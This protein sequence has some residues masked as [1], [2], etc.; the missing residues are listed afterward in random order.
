MR[1]IY[2]YQINKS[3]VGKI[4]TLCG[5]V[6][7]IRDCGKLLFIDF[8]DHTG[9]IQICFECFDKNIHINE[10]KKLK[11]ESCVQI[12]GIVKI[13]KIKSLSKEPQEVE[14][15]ATNL[16]IINIS[17]P[18]PIDFNYKNSE[19]KYLK[20]RYLYIRRSKLFKI[21][22]LRSKITNYIRKVMEKR[23]FIDI[24]T[25]ILSHSTT[26]GA[27]DY[28]VHSRIH[29][30]MFYS[31]P[32]SPQ[33]FKQILMISGIDKYYQIAKC[34]RD[35]D[36]RSDRQPEFTQVDCEIS[37]DNGEK[38]RDL[39]EIL[40]KKLWIKFFNFELNN[41]PIITYNDSIIRF[42]SD[43]PDLRNSLELIN[44]TNLFKINERNKIALSK[45]K[46]LAIILPLKVKLNFDKLKKY[47]NYLKYYIKKDVFLAYVEDI[48][49]YEFS[50][51]EEIICNDSNIVDNLLNLIKNKNKIIL[52]ASRKDC[53]YEIAG[54]LRIKIGLEFN[55]T[56][57]ESWKPVWIVNFPLFKTKEKKLVSVHHPFTSPK[58]FN[59]SKIFKNPLSFVSNSY[60]LVINGV[61][62]GSG[63]SRIHKY[64]IQKIIF[65]V[66]G[67]AEETQ[68]KNF[69]FFLNA[70]KY[71]APPHAGFAFGLDRIVMLISKTNNIRNVIAFP[72][73]TSAYDL[74]TGSPS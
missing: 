51:F 27:R 48:N 31:L 19:E 1:N 8:R 74:M 46:I 59:K 37:F 28:L 63:S 16:N 50:F 26:E 53:V 15:K 67:I 5:W 11:N 70:L 32:Q 42:G 52:I 62:I 56:D 49:K 18:L 17:D 9:I 24:E 38:V 64:E 29:P 23:K 44:V 20:F 4:V 14:V 2:C 40:I 73:T 36:L 35:E 72:K 21:L 54:K 7:N 43:K 58:N 10:S 22:K 34:F 71:G 6:E 61:E 25:P 13:K 3:H 33:L 69:G 57:I 68:N 60:D 47:T 45:Y 55:I 39:I 65:D 66:L 41:F 30:G 12:T